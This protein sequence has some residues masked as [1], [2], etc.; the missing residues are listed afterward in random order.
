[1]IDKLFARLTH[2]RN[3]PGRSHIT[4]HQGSQSVRGSGMAMVFRSNPYNHRKAS[5]YT[6]SNAASSLTSAHKTS[7]AEATS[8]RTYRNRF[9]PARSAVS[10][11]CDAQSLPH[12]AL[13]RTADDPLLTGAGLMPSP[14]PVKEAGEN[15]RCKENSTSAQGDPFI[16]IDRLTSLSKSSPSTSTPQAELRKK[17]RGGRLDHA[18]VL[19]FNNKRE[20][21]RGGVF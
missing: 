9:T 16:A 10:I 6:S 20:R 2:P 5:R 17:G 4:W 13:H 14:S 15:R 18:K 21:R 3:L 1:M 19:V 12:N 7:G 11:I 8:C